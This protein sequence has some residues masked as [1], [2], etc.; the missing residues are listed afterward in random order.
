MIPSS[1]KA[2]KQDTEKATQFCNF[3]RH[4][5]SHFSNLSSL[6]PSVLTLPL[7]WLSVIVPL[8]K[9]SPLF[10]DPF[11]GVLQSDISKMLIQSYIAFCNE[12]HTCQILLAPNTPQVLQEFLLHFYSFGR[13]ANI[14]GHV[15]YNPDTTPRPQY[16][17]IA[18]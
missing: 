17:V 7:C 13:S 6:F 15:C 10:L 1:A 2:L 18:K 12:V 11:P 9:L 4:P 16:T 5:M 8:H 14:V 3:T